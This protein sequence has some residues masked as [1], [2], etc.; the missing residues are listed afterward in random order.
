MS[1]GEPAKRL[2]I[3]VAPRLFADALARAL[4]S[5]YRTVVADPATWSPSAAEPVHFDAAIT[6][7]AALPSHVSV[8]RLLR[9]PEPSSGAT[10]GTLSIGSVERRVPIGGLAAIAAVLGNGS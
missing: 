6:G 10:L 1:H 3:A 2:L 4:C 7:S 5:D 8:D 9:L